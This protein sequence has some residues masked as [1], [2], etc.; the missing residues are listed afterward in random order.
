[1]CIH[2]HCE[3]MTSE[4]VDWSHCKMRQETLY[5]S[6]AL[7]MWAGSR[8]DIK[9]LRR[10]KVAWP[11]VAFAIKE[12]LTLLWK[13]ASCSLWLEFPHIIS[14]CSSPTTVSSSALTLKVSMGS[15]AVK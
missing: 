7:P 3:R 10:K 13:L 6:Y 9:Q 1:M 4:Q 5:G 12:D 2:A 8:G 15:T 11:Y 14:V